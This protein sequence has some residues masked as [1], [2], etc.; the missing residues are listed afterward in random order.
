MREPSITGSP[1]S[2]D[3][4]INSAS[5]STPRL[6]SLTNAM[7]WNII[8]GGMDMNKIRTTA[9]L[10]K[11]DISGKY[12][13]VR[14]HMAARSKRMYPM[15]S[16]TVYAPFECIVVDM[17][18]LQV[19]SIDGAIYAHNFKDKHTKMAWSYP[20]MDASADTFLVVLNDLLA[21]LHR[22]K[23]SIIR[24]D[25]GSNYSANKVRTHCESRGIKLETAVVKAPHQIQIAEKNHDI[26]L[27]TMRALMSFANAPYR[28]WANCIVWTCM[29]HNVSAIDY[30]T[31]VAVIPYHATNQTIDTNLLLPFG[32]L[33]IVHRDKDQVNDGKLDPRGLY[34]VFIGLADRFDF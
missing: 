22:F 26:L 19:K 7:K 14:E 17:I 31:S 34:G 9:K 18:T 5:F 28:L 20:V 3:V 33:I 1:S 23:V 6:A 27:S 12:T 16:P 8:F 10:L 25:A 13:K 4:A 29:L 2:S 21:R 15:V 24:A 11:F 32:C 30:G